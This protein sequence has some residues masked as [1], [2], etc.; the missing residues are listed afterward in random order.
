MKKKLAE[1]KRKAQE[2][3]T[4][5]SAQKQERDI[6]MIPEEESGA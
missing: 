2:V 1:R 6:Y 5:R 4:R 3:Q